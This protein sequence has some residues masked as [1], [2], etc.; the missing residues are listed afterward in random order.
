MKRLSHQSSSDSF[1]LHNQLD[2]SQFCT[3]A[4]C[5]GLR[6]KEV[7]AVKKVK[8]SLSSS[9][10]QYPLLMLL[11]LVMEGV[12][13][14]MTRRS[15]EMATAWTQQLRSQKKAGPVPQTAREV[16][17]PLLPPQSLNPNYEPGW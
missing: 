17:A 12:S 8:S 10:L 14:S 4:A 9:W 3:L 11:L 13:P 16:R 15:P 5:L 6:K 7:L 1:T 2:Q